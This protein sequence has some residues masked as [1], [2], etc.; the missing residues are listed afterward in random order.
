MVAR[1]KRWIL[2]AA[3]VLVIAA[4]VALWRLDHASLPPGLASG[5][6]R[7]EGDEVSV[8]AKFGGRVAWI[9]AEEGDL[10]E[11]GQ[12]LARMDTA[13]QEALLREAKA[14]AR[15]A[16]QRR[17]TA[18]ALVAQR[19]SEHEL[20][21]AE[22][23]RSLRLFQKHVEPESQLDVKRSRLNTARAAA[24]AAAAQQFDAEAAIEAADA[25]VDR[26]QTQIDDALLVSPVR[27][28]VLY[29][30]AE[31]GEVLPSGGSVLTLLDLTDIYMEIF[32][33]SQEAARVRIGADARIV[34]DAAPGYVIP[35]TVS[36]VA[37]E[38]QFTPKEVETRSE[39][40][41]LMFRVKVRIPAAVVEPR[42]QVVKTGIRG[43]AYVM[44]AGTEPSAWPPWLEA[45]L[46]S[47]PE[48]PMPEAR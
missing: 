31:P 47:L 13:E 20:A 7:I 33:P 23:R 8:A 17:N 40:D 24:D 42:I 41:K 26:I 38:A 45:R 1:A 19:K 48:R 11:P 35:A 18:A 27:G 30:L 21:A 44:L 9:R 22:F 28:R 34:L 6:G 2:A 25:A 12:A 36:F 15:E 14:Q 16:V 4:A 3:V 29:R 46:P 39:R 10:V 32:L 37:P 43:M 5:N